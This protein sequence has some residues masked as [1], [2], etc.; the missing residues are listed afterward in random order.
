MTNTIK[1]TQYADD[2]TVFLG[3]VQSLNNLFNLL[4]QCEN[5]SGLWK[6]QSIKKS[7]LLWLGAWRYREDTLL[8]LRLSEEPIYTLGVHFSYD[9]QLAA[10]KNSFDRQ[11][12]AAKK[13]TKHLVVKRY[14]HLR[15]N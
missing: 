3:D 1:L 7:E 11:D 8:N 2:N 5:C 15:K 14:I 4:A 12:P 13:N 9:K 6:N 10:K